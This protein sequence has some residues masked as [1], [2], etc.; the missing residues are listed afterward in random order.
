M[1]DHASLP[2]DQQLTVRWKHLPDGKV[3]EFDHFVY[4]GK[5]YILLG[6]FV[7]GKYSIYATRRACEQRNYQL[8]LDAQN[9]RSFFERHAVLVSILAGGLFVLI[10]NLLKV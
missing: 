6:A 2:S 10:L 1:L 9:A 7:G 5:D 3:I 8:S 4:P